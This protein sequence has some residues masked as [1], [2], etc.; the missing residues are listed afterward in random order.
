M[1]ALPRLRAEYGPDLRLADFA[2]EP[3][4]TIRTLRDILSNPASL[5]PP[6]T[7]VPGLV[8]AERLTV[9]AA[10]E[11][12]GKSTAAAYA[13]A[14]VSRGESFAGTEI[15]PGTVLWLSAEEHE[16]DIAQRAS[17]FGSNWDTLLI[18]AE[19]GEDGLATLAQAIEAVHPDFVVVD[20]LESWAEGLFED[21]NSSAQMGPIMTALRNA[22][23]GGPGILCLHHST[24]GEGGGYRGSTAIGAGCD[25]MVEMVADEVDTTARVFKPRGRIR[26]LQGY[27][28]KLEGNAYRVQAGELSPDARILAYVAAAPGISRTALRDKVGGSH[29]AADRVIDTLVARGAMRDEVSAAGYHAYFPVIAGAT[30]G[31]GSEPCPQA[32]QLRPHAGFPGA[33]SETLP[34]SESLGGAASA[35][36]DA[37][38][39][40]ALAEGA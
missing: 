20:A 16:A 36:S 27:T 19:R 17:D 15:L 11:K 2:E 35:D 8:W 24:K 28:L 30:S 5:V 34:V 22:A 6:R 1:T 7:I 26:G 29:R 3:S 23:R 13:A 12:F 9:L 14:R 38:A 18:L 32:A 39:R 33:A 40:Q 4:L 25:V 31:Q 10:R 21:A 37:E